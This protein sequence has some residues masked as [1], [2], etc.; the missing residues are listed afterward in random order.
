MILGDSRPR[1]ATEAHQ[2][3]DHDQVIADQESVG[4]ETEAALRRPGAGPT[5][6]RMPVRSRSLADHRR[7][8]GRSPIANVAIPAP[9]GDYPRGDWRRRYADWRNRYNL[10]LRGRAAIL[11]S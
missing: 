11:W 1:L 9:Q 5:E 10:H 4:L 6:G 2:G 8:I 7:C 3:S